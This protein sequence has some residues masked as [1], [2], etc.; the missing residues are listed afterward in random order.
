[1][2]HS[3]NIMKALINDNCLCIFWEKAHPAKF[4]DKVEN[5]IENKILIPERLNEYLKRENKSVLIRNSFEELKYI[6]S[7]CG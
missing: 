3:R 6:Y 2:F 1:M 5:A 7:L 4:I